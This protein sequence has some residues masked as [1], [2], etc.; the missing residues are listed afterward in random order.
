ML[1]YALRRA[2][3]M[4]PTLVGITLIAFG[5]LALTPM[6]P[7]TSEAPAH[8][9]RLP[10]F[11]NPSPRDVR[12]LAEASVEQIAQGD[13]PAQASSRLVRLGGAALPFVLPHLDALGPEQRARVALSLEPVARRMGLLRA[14]GFRDGDEAVVFWQRFWEERAVDFKAS[15]VRRAVRRLGSYGSEARRTELV[16]LDTFALEEIVDGFGEVQT[17]DDVARV[18]RMIEVA[19]HVTGR[20]DKLPPEASVSDASRCVTRWRHWWLDARSDYVV[21]AGPGRLAAMLLETRYGHWALSAGAMRLG[22][23]PGGAPVFDTLAQRGRFTL[24]LTLAA[25]LLAYIAAIGI[26]LIGAWRKDSPADHVPATFVL[27]SFALTPLLIGAALALVGGT[28]FAVAA[29]LIAAAMGIIASPARQQRLRGID[30]LATECV[31]AARARGAGPW[32]VMLGQAARMSGITMASLA[33]IDFPVAFTGAL[34]VERLMSLPGIAQDLTIAVIEGNAPL[35]MAF[36]VCS[37]CLC[38]LMLVAGDVA[39]AWLDPRCRRLLLK[40]PT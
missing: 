11:L 26:G 32:R 10:V 27:A 29:A 22:V 33:A 2:L 6:R 36:G 14:E 15:V 38:A 24:V 3:W 30:A 20:D 40:E 31:R 4:L 9:E 21:L 23:G 39:C 34:V 1:R 12:S 37:A 8:H 5:F 35:L 17:S 18:A 19:A 13:Q 25:Q 16:E 28:R 7:E